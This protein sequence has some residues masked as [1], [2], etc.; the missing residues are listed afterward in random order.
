MASSVDSKR[1]ERSLQFREQRFVSVE[2]FPTGPMTGFGPPTGGSNER[3][4][5]GRSDDKRMV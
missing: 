3:E 4:E 5:L 1:E 2:V